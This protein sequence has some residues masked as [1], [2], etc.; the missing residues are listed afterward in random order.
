MSRQQAERKFSTIQRVAYERDVHAATVR[1]WI[2]SGIV[3]AVKVGGRVLVEN[4]SLP[5]PGAPKGTML[6]A[7]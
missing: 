3:R 1:R 6:D 5:R 4:D 2:E 7:G